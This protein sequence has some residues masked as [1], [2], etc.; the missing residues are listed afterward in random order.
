MNNVITIFL[1]FLIFLLLPLVV[2]VLIHNSLV[3]KEEAVFSA[4]SQVESNYQRRNDLIPV[5]TE[6]ISRFIKHEEDTLT[7]VTRQRAMP[8]VDLQEAVTGLQTAQL[9]STAS[10][11]ELGGKPPVDE[12]ML[13]KMAISQEKAFSG[14]KS[15]LAVMESYPELHSSDQFMSLQA[16]LEG[17]ENRINVA[18]MQFNKAAQAFNAAIRKMPNS[19]V[20]SV[21]KLEKMV[22][23]KAE[24]SAS[25]SKQ[26]N[27]E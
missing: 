6:S 13:S 16:Q 12:V 19:L 14:M 15:L 26:L 2:W 9:D 11:Q 3:S 21:N 5:L 18:R 20:A 22:Y 4:W 10:I 25:K 24:E 7:A 17:T 1:G 27:M 23:F 8:Y